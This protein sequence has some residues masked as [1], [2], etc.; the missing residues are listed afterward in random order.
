MILLQ[1][2]QQ[3]T[4]KMRKQSLSMNRD[5]VF[6][7]FYSEA[8][9]YIINTNMIFIYIWN[10]ESINMII[11]WHAHLDNLADYKEE[12]CYADIIKNLEF[13]IFH[14]SRSVTKISETHLSNDIIIYDDKF[15]KVIALITVV[16]VYSDLWQDCEKTVNISESNYLQ[17]F[18]KTNWKQNMI[19][20]L[21][22]IYLL[23]KEACWLID[24]KFDELHH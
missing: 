24:N 7:L 13:V 21:K 14:T 10:N 9:S 8:Y 11:S 17:V 1:S 5:L 19:K 2:V 6:H 12:E 22:Q 4:V 18:L 3:I 15:N 16:K 20:L 23:D